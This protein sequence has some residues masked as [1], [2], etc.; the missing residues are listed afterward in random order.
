MRMAVQYDDVREFELK[1]SALLKTY[2][3]LTESDIGT[4]F[5][6]GAKLLV[7]NCPACLSTE[8]NKSFT[9][10]GLQYWECA[11]CK[12]LYISPRP[13]E[14]ASK[15]RKFWEE[16]L[17]R[18]TEAKR[19][20]KI[21]RPRVEWIIEIIEEYLPHAKRFFS[22]NT[23]HHPFIEELVE[24]NYFK[25]ITILNPKVN[26][27]R[28]N[29]QKRKAQF[30]EKP[31][32]TLSLNN[33]ADGVSLFE[34]VDRLSDV[35]SFFRALGRILSVGGLCFL[36]TISVSGFDVQVLWEKSNSIFPPDR[37]NAFS[38]EGLTILFERHGF[39]CLELSTPGLLDIEMVANA[40]KEDPSL[41][42]PRFVKYLLDNR[43]STTHQSFQ[44]FLQMNRLSSSTRIV[45]RKK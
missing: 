40:Y 35:D 5:L 34:V 32:N 1:P 6:E 15:A 19:R 36:T 17:S 33:L 11:H 44:E 16:E 18:A 23:I 2:L 37:I 20:E 22:I 3:Q 45:L 13:E 8:R 31:I 41:D 38:I 10:F 4:Y 26:L 29:Y 28:I 39:E 25:E 7:C 9:K 43:G 21:F 14:S 42:L 27:D 30:V 24:S 12:T